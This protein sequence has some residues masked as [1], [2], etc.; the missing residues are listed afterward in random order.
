MSS[1]SIQTIEIDNTSYIPNFT[2]EIAAYV[3]FFEKGPINTPVFISN[4]NEFKFI[5]GR[6]LDMYHNDWYQVYNFLQYAS[7]IWVIR[8]SGWQQWNANNGDRI[9]INSKE[10]FEEIYD[11]ISLVNNRF[12]I[13]AKTAGDAGNL[14]K[15]GIIDVT[16]WNENIHIGYGSYAKE[17]FTYFE[18]DYQG[19]VI[20]RK[21]QIVEKFYIHYDDIN[22]IDSKYVYFKFNPLDHGGNYYDDPMNEYNL[23]ELSKGSVDFATDDD[24]RTAHDI[25]KNKD[26][27]DIDIIIGNQ[28]D[29]QLAID[30]AESRRDCIAFIGIPTTFLTFLKTEQDAN[31]DILYTE[32]GLIIV[33]DIYNTPKILN[34]EDILKLFDYI[35]ILTESQFVHFTANIKEQIDGFTGKKKLV[36]IA[37]DVAGLKSKASKDYP[38]TPGAGLERGIILNGESIYMNILSKDKD[39]L[40][41]KGLNFIEN[42]FLISQKT[43]LSVNS[44][45]SRINIRSLFNHL[46]KTVEKIL[47]RFIFE[48]NRESVRRT[49]AL[50]VK[51]VLKD[52]RV[53][54]GI[55]SGKVEVHKGK[56]DNEIIVDVYVKPLYVAEYIQLRITNVGTNTIS[57]ILSST[58]G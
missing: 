55:E 10:D 14:L 51:N 34:T 20:F 43:F 26:T 7:G 57:D 24:F 32:D 2:N 3:G 40:Y 39:R 30:I 37:A 8:A 28:Y 33:L 18:E 38:W 25:L 58:L 48:E 54:R 36:N 12:R 27:Y 4:I 29:N 56:T 53:N 19:I 50:E 47:R 35:N 41:K 15:I 42:G 22:T 21:D 49:I 13:I 16:K 6:G 45:F 46:E 23:I 44:S 17:L 1:P 9:F 52:M 11:S 31:N 5:F